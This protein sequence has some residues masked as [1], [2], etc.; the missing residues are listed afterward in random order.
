M[1]DEIMKLIEK[2]E[3]DS[4]VVLFMKM[5]KTQYK[6]MCNWLVEEMKA[7]DDCCIRNTIAIILGDLRYNG[8]VDALIQ[9][10]QNPQNANSRGTL[11]YALK[12]LKCEKN[13]TD[14]IDILLNGNFETKWNMH[15]LILKKRKLLSKKDRKK[16]KKEIKKKIKALEIELGLYYDLKEKL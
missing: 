2:N 7:T 6:E 16:Y 12:E 9:L 15:D 13:L 14:L 10:I 11:I 8:A 1:H 4:V 5:K 3:I